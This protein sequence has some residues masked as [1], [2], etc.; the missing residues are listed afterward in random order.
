MMASKMRQWAPAILSQSSNADEDE[1]CLKSMVTRL[2]DWSSALADDGTQ[3]HQGRWRLSTGNII[4]VG[5]II[6]PPS[7]IHSSEVCMCVI[8]AK[9]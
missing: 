8:N 7:P 3:S 6:P 5:N 2:S 9:L 4:L 1:K